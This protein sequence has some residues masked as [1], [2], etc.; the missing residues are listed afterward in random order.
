MI[1]VLSLDLGQVGYHGQKAPFH[2]EIG[3]WALAALVKQARRGFRV[4]ELSLIERPG[5]VWDYV[6]V[7]PIALPP[8]LAHHAEAKAS[9]GDDSHPRLSLIPVRD[10]DRNF[11][12]AWDDTDPESEAWLARREGPLFRDYAERLFRAAREAWEALGDNPLISQEKRTIAAHTHPCSYLG[13][14]EAIASVCDRLHAPNEPRHA[15]GYYHK[16]VELLADP[17]T[18]SVAYRGKG[19]WEVLRLVCAEQRR[20]A[21]ASGL[22]PSEALKVCALMDYRAATRCWGA[23][24]RWYSE[25]LGKGSLWLED[26]GAGGCSIADLVNGGHENPVLVLLDSAGD[27]IRGFSREDG[28]GWVLYRREGA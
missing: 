6:H 24:V 5:D 21:D 19:D 23:E 20:R 7:R 27:H 11:F 10:F 12:R 2:V 4:Y 9:P 28:E 13:R 14:N 26:D 15:P 3:S 8:R 17:R 18:A 16:L 25:G 1:P 22:T